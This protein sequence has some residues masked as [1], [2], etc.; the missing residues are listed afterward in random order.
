MFDFIRNINP[1]ELA[2]IVFILVILFGAKVISGL[3]KTSGETVKELK[4]IKKEFTDAA[5]LS[6]EDKSSKK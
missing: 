2:I 6:D 4:K 1:T 3:A 5:D